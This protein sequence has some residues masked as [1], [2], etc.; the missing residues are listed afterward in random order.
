MKSHF[1]KNTFTIWARSLLS[2]VILEMLNKSKSL[3][4][5]YR[6]NIVNCIFGNYNT[7]YDHVVL[8]NV[9]LGDFTYIAYNANIWNTTI[10][11]FCSIGSDVKCGLGLHPS[12]VFVSTHPIFYSPDKQSQVSF[13]NKKY[14]V[15]ESPIEIGNDVWIGSNVLIV[16]GTTIGDG[17]IIASGS[18]V[19]K[20]VPPYAIVGGIPAKIIRYRFEEDEIDYLLKLKWWNL[21]SS[22]LKN[23]YLLFHDIKTLMNDNVIKVNNEI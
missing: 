10:G 6:T 11:K 1:I 4:L 7:I 19:T 18:V 3:K 17:A 23:N 5:G 2:T 8:R 9:S 12:K 13:A 22:W 21:D 15:E 20:N 16:A 14:F